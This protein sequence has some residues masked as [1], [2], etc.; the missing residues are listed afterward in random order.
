MY[1]KNF[2]TFISVIIFSSLSL[3]AQSQSHT[4]EGNVVDTNGEPLIGVSILELGTSSG[5]VTDMDGGFK[6]NVKSQNAIL[7]FTYIGFKEQE[8]IVDNRS[9]IH[10]ILEDE[11]SVLDEVVVVGY[12]TMRRSDLT[13]AI[14]S[15]SMDDIPSTS[16]TN[17]TQSLRGFA[18]GLNV[19]GGSG[20]GSLPGMTIR[21]QNTLSASSAPLVVLDGIIFNGSIADINPADV[22]R[23][24]I[25]KDA[26]S[27]AIYG[28]RSAN[29]VV[30][31]TTKKGKSSKPSVNFDTSFGV[32][33]YTNN[34]VKWMNAEQYA[35]R[36]VDY[37][38]MQSLY[39][40]YKKM[41][42][43]PSDKGGKPT[44]PGY[45]DEIVMG[46]LKSEDERKNWQ[47][48]NDIDWIKEVTRIAPKTNY[49]LNISGGGEKHNYFASVSHTN[50][51]GVLK[52]DE[53]KRTT[54]NLKVEGDIADWLTLG[55]N[56]SN[57]YRDYSGI[58]ADMYGAQNST[59]L[60]SK[61]DEDG[62]YPTRFNDEFLMRHPLRYEYI[63]D[64]DLRKNIFL[65]GYAKVKFP[66][67]ENLVYDFNYSN[68]YSSSARKTYYPSYVDDGMAKQGV[69]NV[70]NSEGTYWLF[71]H[72]L[73][74]VETFN[75]IHKIDVTLLYTQDK[76]HGN[77]STIDANKFS[78]E[79]LGYNNVGFAEQYSIGSGAYEQS[80][81]GYMTR[82]NYSLMNKYLFTG[83]FRRD[84]F[85]GFGE[86]NKLANFYSASVAWNISE[87][88]F[89]SDARNWLDHLKLRLSYGQNGNQGIGRYSSLSRMVTQNYVFDS[90]PYI[91]LAP[92][93]LGNEGLGWEIT[94]SNNF[95]VDFSVLD[96]RVSGNVDLY[97]AKTNDVL[98][99][100]NLPGSTGYAN[101]WTNIGQIKNRGIEVE[102][103]TVNVKS[104]L[105]W[106]S[107]LVFSLNRDEIVDLY[108]DGKDDIGNQ[109]FIGEPISAIYD[110]ERKGDVWTEE[111]LYSG[112]ILNGFYPGQFKLTDINGD[113]KITASDDRKIVGYTTPN[114]RFG[115]GNTLTYSSFSLYFFLNSIQGGNGYYIG[116]LKRLL[117][118]TSDYDY[119]Q[120]A[121]QPAI[122]ENWTPDNGVTNTPAI[123][124]YPTIAS[125]NYQDR[126]FIRLQDLSFSYNFDK[127]LLRQFKFEN[128][129]LYI[130]GHN[131]YTWTNWEGFD[132]ELGGFYDMMIRDL[133]IGLKIGF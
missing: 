60:G 106:E 6:L 121:N 59:P 73:R 45:S 1:M 58:S 71:N 132:P 110:Y 51:S 67:L 95:G 20:A 35:H 99:R 81:L 10:V 104:P 91:G 122:R 100:R 41:P 3:T 108:G 37:S 133:S 111:D 86:K 53:F 115:I 65:T 52:G 68:N 44:H 88:K 31:I 116:D 79:I 47:A 29:G 46:F 40:W 43:G 107:R 117:E 113:N 98:V 89:M 9:S 128:L 78:N 11:T 54:I 101:V 57:S 19:A 77:N 69:A 36:L 72:I 85:S 127:K 25:L 129:Q 15:I 34:P 13:G 126:S 21:G 105:T 114:Y 118:A 76:L 24:D 17:L 84:G 131:L 90:T 7:R 12:G 28:S 64:S 48:G 97:V 18:A 14:K 33:D 2:I 27:A 62:R 39:T 70:D 32:Q 55:L 16:V 42:T 94:N 23:I 4:V 92:S 83:T 22:D 49:N 74:Y 120:R 103:N 102:L 56:S 50:Q 63:D 26:S 8:I 66:F 80:S 119:A 93:T 125:G 87:E 38:Y 124:N 5:T 75:E 130:S 96:Q 109:W 30:H 61:Y 123:Y 112:N 82:L